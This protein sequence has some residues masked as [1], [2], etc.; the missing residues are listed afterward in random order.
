MKT[1]TSALYLASNTIPSSPPIHLP[2]LD[3]NRK[4]HD[5]KQNLEILTSQKHSESEHKEDTDKYE[6][7][8]FSE[9]DN[10]NKET[11]SESEQLNKR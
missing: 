9:D 7:I 6:S 4:S 10:D 2:V 3:A 8:S 5:K 11:K 1:S